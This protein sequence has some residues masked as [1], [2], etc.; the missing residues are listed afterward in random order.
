MENLRG[1]GKTIVLTTH[2]LDEAER[3]ADRVAILLD[4]RIKI[5]GS[6]REVARLAALPS[7]VS[8]GMPA[9]LRSGEIP[10]RTASI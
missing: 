3:L 6:T 4:G 10:A 9:A 5:T 7:R 1:L 2:Y 8:F